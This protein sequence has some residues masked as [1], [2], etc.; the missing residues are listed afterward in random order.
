[1]IIKYEH[2]FLRYNKN[3]IVS[4]SYR[5]ADSFKIKK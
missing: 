1:M 5:Q 3:K 4:E 2:V